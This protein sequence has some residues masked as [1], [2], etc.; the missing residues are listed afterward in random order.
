MK[1]LGI[2]VMLTA[3]GGGVALAQEPPQPA[4]KSE[5]KT[6]SGPPMKREGK[7]RPRKL[8]AEVTAVDAAA[9]KLTVKE[10]KGKPVTLSVGADVRIALGGKLSVLSD[11][12]AG[13]KVRVTYEGRKDAP[14]I[15]KILVIKKRTMAKR[16]ERPKGAHKP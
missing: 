13:D 9:G 2:L 12:E 15:K 7:A 3:L 14:A 4:P 1:E 5:M 8:L 11:I 16:E 6:E 10:R